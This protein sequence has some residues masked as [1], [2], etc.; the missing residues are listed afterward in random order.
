MKQL[1]AFLFVL[2]IALFY[3]N[4][5]QNR[6][7]NFEKLSIK[8]NSKER[9]YFVSTN[10]KKLKNKNPPIYIFLHGITLNWE[11]DEELKKNY[12]KI[13]N[14]AEKYNF[15]AIFPQ[16][17]KG[18][19]DWENGKYKNYYCWSTSKEIDRNFIKLLADKVVSDY[20]AN[21]DKIFLSG[22]SNGAFFVVDYIFRHEDNDFTGY[23]I[24]SGGGYL[25]K[26]DK[27]N[28][29][30]QRFYIFMSVGDH[31]EYQYN[32]M[33]DLYKT[34]L[35]LNWKENI[36]IKFYEFRGFHKINIDSIEKEIKF[37]L[38]NND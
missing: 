24:H 26:K 14:L 13:N 31:D 3:I 16:G 9:F 5:I 15:I 33:K 19:C 11:Q 29:Y 12:Y 18:S 36:N 8:V 27:I 22:F 1:R 38:N 30:K 7:T 6:I 10:Y 37:F 20:K 17:S 4:Y 21:K 25:L 23:G 34:F 32:Q 2:L 28:K 35:K